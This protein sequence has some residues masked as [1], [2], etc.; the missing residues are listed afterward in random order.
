MTIRHV[1]VLADDCDSRSGTR[2]SS[3]SRQEV[4]VNAQLALETADHVC[5]VDQVD[6]EGIVISKH[7]KAVAKLI[8][9]A[10]VA[11]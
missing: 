9:R 3:A 2:P 7:G 10:A 1:V 8:E 11:S 4:A 5:T 6:A